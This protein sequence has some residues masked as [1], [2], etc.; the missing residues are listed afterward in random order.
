M[1][2][3]DVMWTGFFWLGLETGGGLYERG[4]E[5]LGSIKIA[6][7]EGRYSMELCR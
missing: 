7:Q 1:D 6:F 5:L 3:R 2:F 4:D